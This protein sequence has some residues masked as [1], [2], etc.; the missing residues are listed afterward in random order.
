MEKG[1]EKDGDFEDLRDK[2]YRCAWR[3]CSLLLLG[4]AGPDP[5]E[6]AVP[7]EIN[8]NVSLIFL[9]YNRNSTDAANELACMRR[10]LLP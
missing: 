3:T 2:T 10:S 4:A 1:R 6:G 8:P 5:V 7:A 9:G